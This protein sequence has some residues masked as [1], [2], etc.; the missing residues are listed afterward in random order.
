MPKDTFLSK[1]KMHIS[2]EYVQLLS[3]FERATSVTEDW[4]DAR[5][6]NLNQRTAG[7]L[8]LALLLGSL[9]YMGLFLPDGEFPVEHYVSIEKGED[10][11]S[12]A[13][14]LATDNV[15]RNTRTLELAVRI[16]G[17]SRTVHA[18]DYLFAQ[19]IGTLA[20]ARTITTGTYGLE[21]VRITI[22]EGATVVDMATIF[23]RRLFKFNA[24]RFI[25]MALPYEGYL[26]PDTYYFL[27]NVRESEVL[28]T[29]N[30]NFKNQVQQF[31]AQIDASPYTFH[32]I[33][34]LASIIE[35]EA[36]KPRDQKFISGVLYNRLEMDMRL[37][38]DATFTYTHNK[39]TYEITLDE[40][41][42]EDNP[43]NTYVHKGL[44]PGPIAAVGYSAIDAALNPT[45]NNYIFYLADRYGNTYYSRTYEEHLTKKRQY[46]D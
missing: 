10:L 34:T 26:Y 17:G 42:D 20:V 45:E 5:L 38:V 4:H 22:P 14:T 19:P 7:V 40:L 2:R 18:G 41:A 31:A 24:Q 16:L 3:R 36:W 32:E 30:D 35:K 1:L 37:Q 28:H 13:T 15:V 21:P 27:P 11:H 6:E 33:I 12:I 39:G 44:P 46:V 29:M 25:D 43:Y 8:L 9:L 23:D